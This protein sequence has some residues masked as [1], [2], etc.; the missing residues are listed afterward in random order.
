MAG[1]YKNAFA[2]D[3][4]EDVEKGSSSIMDDAGKEAD[5]PNE[6]AAQK[7]TTLHMVKVGS[8]GDSFL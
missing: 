8:S 5:H 4:S 2:G 3:S 1:T 6:L 7:E